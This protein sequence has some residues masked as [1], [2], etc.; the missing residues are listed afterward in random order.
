M[1]LKKLIKIISDYKQYEVEGNKK[2]SLDLILAEANPL[3]NL[4]TRIDW[5]LKLVKWVRETNLIEH[6]PSTVPHIKLKYLFMVLERNPAINERVGLVLIH[7]LQELSCI[8]FFCEV[9]LP[10]QIGLLGELGNIILTKILPKKSIGSQLSELMPA[11]FPTEE[12]SFWLRNLDDLTIHKLLQL[13]G[14]GNNN[15]PHIQSD[16]EES[17]IYLTS[18]IVALGLSPGIRKRIPHKKMKSLPFFSL[19]GKLNLYLKMKSHGKD[20]ALTAQVLLEFRALLQ[21][22]LEAIAEV[23]LH[24]NRFGVS[25]HLVFQ[26]EKLKLFISRTF[27]LLEIH[28]SGHLQ[29]T[30][31]THFISDLTEQHIVHKNALAIFS[32]NAT[33]LSQKI[34]EA[35]SQTG[36]HYIAKDSAEYWHM[37]KIA[38]GGGLLTALTVYLKNFFGQLAFN[39]FIYGLFSTLNYSGSFLLIQFCG[40]TLATKQPAT[41]ASALAQKL[42]SS[43]GLKGIESLTDEIVLL[44]RTQFAAVL[45]NLSAVIPTVLFINVIFHWISGK[46]IYSLA[47]AQYA[48]QST[49]ILGPS[50][51]YG[52]F[53]GFLLWLSSIISG[54]SDNWY[55]FHQLNS[56]ISHNIKIKAILGKEGAQKLALF[57]DKNVTGIAGN[58]SLGI[59]LGLVPELLKFTGIPLEVRHVTLAAGALAAALPTLGIGSLKSQEF[60]RAFLGIG[61]IGI[62]N[63]SVS[64]LLALTV[65]FKAKRIAADRKALILQSVLKRFSQKPL[66]FFVAKSST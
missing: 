46:W 5:I 58:I 50:V 39:K 45:G 1:L 42:E 57:F 54:W 13:F 11:L 10:S 27:S 63:I 33:L 44:T 51:I 49:D 43:E 59:F 12:D 37:V 32:S 26:I 65:A 30:N 62:L 9:G 25:T 55:T 17:L 24:F 47:S 40:F 60:L 19:A 28:D 41:T 48:L 23:Y 18:Q 2:I 61:L 8:E 3:E 52:I 64:F 7:T 31:I 6:E 4:E 66:S 22:S 38:L 16:L 21:E 53:T 20:P 29:K 34:I 36:E 56:L 14:V 15:Y 35:N